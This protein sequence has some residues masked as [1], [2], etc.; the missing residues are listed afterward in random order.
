[1]IN[2]IHGHSILTAIKLLAWMYSHIP[3]GVLVLEVGS[4]DKPFVRS[5]VLLDRHLYDNTE[6]GGCLLVDR[7][8]VIGALEELPFKSKS[9]DFIICHHLLEHVQDPATCIDELMRVGRRGSIRVPSALAEKLVSPVYHRWL[10]RLESGRLMFQIKASPVFDPEIKRF[11]KSKVL[12]GARYG[13]FYRAFRDDLEIQLVWDG[14]IFY[15][16]QED[17]HGQHSAGFKAASVVDQSDSHPYLQERN[18]L[19]WNQK[20]RSLVSKIIRRLHG[21][22]RVSLNSL[23]ACPRCK[24]DVVRLER[25]LGCQTCRMIFPIRGAVPVMLREAAYLWETRAGPTPVQVDQSG[26]TLADV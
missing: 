24:S 18:M 17:E 10:I 12:A 5:D 25:G 26:Q 11:M 1:V 13:S 3:S 7:P 2:I 9:F 16:I 15:Q 19:P 4:G 6:R 14:K 23:L 20:A 21:A 8:F 22:P